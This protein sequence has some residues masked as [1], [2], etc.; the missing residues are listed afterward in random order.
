MHYDLGHIDLEQRTLQTI[1]EGATTLQTILR[2]YLPLARPSMSPMA[3][4]PSAITGTTSWAADRH[5]FGVG[6]PVHGRAAGLRLGWI[7]GSTGPSS[8]PP[9]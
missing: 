9:R 6:A 3:L 8:A 4:S 5:Q 2:I 7:R 1:D